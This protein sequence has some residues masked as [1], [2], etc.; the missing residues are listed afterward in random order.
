MKKY[1]LFGYGLYG[2]SL[3]DFIGKDKIL[4]FIDNDLKKCG[5]DEYIELEVIH[6]SVFFE[7]YNGTL[8][9]SIC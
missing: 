1:Y 3:C 8:D 6:S 2:R 5:Y 7:K 4:G 9:D